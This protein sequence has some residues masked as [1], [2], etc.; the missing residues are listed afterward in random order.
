MATSDG[1]VPVRE[2]S[3]VVHSI[4]TSDERRVAVRALAAS[5]TAMSVSSLADRI[6]DS[7]DEQAVRV[8]LHHQHLPKMHDAGVVEYDREGA[9]VRLTPM[10]ERVDAVARRTAEILED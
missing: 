3:D 4:L 6:G 2:R 1:T 5:G 10:G 9:Q 7:E 8:R